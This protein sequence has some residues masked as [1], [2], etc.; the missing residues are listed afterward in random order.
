MR[1]HRTQRLPRDLLVKAAGTALVTALLTYPLWGPQGGGDGILG[2]ITARGPAAALLTAAVFL[3]L[4]AL[5]CRALQ[6]TLTLIPAAARAAP[7]ASVWWMFA[8]PHNFTEDFFIVRN[9]AASLAADGR[10]PAR[11]VRHW[12]LTG[13]GWCALQILSLFPGAAG[14]AGG[15]L[16][17]LLWAAHWVLTVRVNRSLAVRPSTARIAHST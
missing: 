4:V 17:L 16:A 2:E 5:Y 9:V 7:P 13:H 10:V 12:A 3:A 6:R 11:S 14:R 8:I 1:T 15:G